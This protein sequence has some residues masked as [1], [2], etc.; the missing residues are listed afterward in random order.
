MIWTLVVLSKTLGIRR[1][2][3]YYRDVARQLL[4]SQLTTVQAIQQLEL[5]PLTCQLDVLYGH[6]G[7]ELI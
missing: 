2:R 6:E 7:F 5:M 1:R 3:R 4:R